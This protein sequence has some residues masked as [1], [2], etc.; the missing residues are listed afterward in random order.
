MNDVIKLKIPIDD[1]KELLEK[2]EEVLKNML[3]D[4]ELKI[5]Y[6]K[7]KNLSLVYENDSI[8]QLISFSSSKSVDYGLIARNLG[9][10]R[11]FALTERRKIAVK[12]LK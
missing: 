6:V 9:L 12:E 11:Y 1:A 7:S 3:P 4:V 2:V 8:K 5:E 10:A